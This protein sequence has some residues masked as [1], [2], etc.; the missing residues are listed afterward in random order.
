LG[1]TFQKTGNK[2]IEFDVSYIVHEKDNEPEIILFIS[3]ED[4][5]EAMKKSGLM[6]KAMA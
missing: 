5:E 4:E 3:H 1:V 2:P 6:D